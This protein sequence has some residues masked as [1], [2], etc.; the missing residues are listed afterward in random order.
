MLGTKSVRVDLASKCGLRKLHQQQI[1]V[2]GQVNARLKKALKGLEE[3]NPREIREW[4]DSSTPGVRGDLY[5]R[6]DGEV[7]IKE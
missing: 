6:T 3:M 4:V 1:E 7:F 2:A 5:G